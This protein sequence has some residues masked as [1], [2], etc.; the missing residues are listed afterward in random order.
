MP[1]FVDIVTCSSGLDIALVMPVFGSWMAGLRETLVNCAGFDVMAFAK[2]TE[3]LP[4]SKS[5]FYF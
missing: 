4:A 1:W 5:E 2:I 3:M